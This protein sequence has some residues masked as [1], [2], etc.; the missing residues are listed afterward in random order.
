MTTD[1]LP[2]FP[3]LLDRVATS[4]QNAK[5]RYGYAI[6]S[7]DSLGIDRPRRGH[8]YVCLVVIY[9]DRRDCKYKTP[10]HWDVD[11]RHYSVVEETVVTG[12]GNA[13]RGTVVTRQRFRCVTRSLATREQ[14]IAL[15]DKIVRV[16][17]RIRQ[18]ESA[19]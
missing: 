7:I 19:E 17:N 9:D 3:D 1:Q 16:F 12:W 14:A 2:L 10:N 11:I 18:A 13:R 15:A 8:D 6:W 5:L 4:R